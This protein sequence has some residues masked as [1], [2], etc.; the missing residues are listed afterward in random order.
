MLVVVQWRR[1]GVVGI[2]GAGVRPGVTDRGSETRGDL[3]GDFFL[4]EIVCTSV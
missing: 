4:T 1:Y 3:R 2:K